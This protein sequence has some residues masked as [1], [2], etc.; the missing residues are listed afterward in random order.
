M[1]KKDY[2]KNLEIKSILKLENIIEKVLIINKKY[3]AIKSENEITIYSINTIELKFRIPLKPL[4]KKKNDFL[5]HS[6]I[7]DYNYKLRLINNEEKSDSYKL[8]TD[9]N[10]IEINFN[11]NEWKIISELKE[12]IYLIN[13][14]VLLYKNDVLLYKKYAIQILDPKGNLKSKIKATYFELYGL[15]E[16]KN[17]YLIINL[18]LKFLI[19]DVNNNYNIL[20]SKENCYY[21]WGYQHPYILD[22]QTIIFSTILN[23]YIPGV[24]KYIFLDLNDFSE[25]LV[26]N[27]P[28][29]EGD[30]DSTNKLF[31]IHKFDDNIYLQFETTESY[32]GKKWSIVILKNNK[33]EFI[34]KFDDK[35]ILGDNLH[36]LTNN[37][38]L[39]WDFLGKNVKLVH[40]E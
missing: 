39:T 35:G 26:E 6:Y 14:N 5:L 29:E 28:Y 18:K 27:I 17:K 10:L 7:F 32:I 38:I 22:E 23:I 30:Y 40:Y 36:F 3:F 19:L 12:G 24:E 20:Y 2:L 8:L 11:K 15:Y 37:V 25:R 1:K 31:I 33:F 16:I 34:K 21:H 4:N 9:K 13:L